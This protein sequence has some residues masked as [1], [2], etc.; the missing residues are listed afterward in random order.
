MQHKKTN[1]SA[2]SRFTCGKPQ[3]TISCNNIGQANVWGI[4][5]NKNGALTVIK[6]VAC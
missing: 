6:V 4:M 5:K 3:F 1:R 2:L